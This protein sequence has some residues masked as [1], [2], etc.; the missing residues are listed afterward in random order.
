MDSVEGRYE[1]AA[2]L[3]G[4]ASFL[5][6]NCNVVAFNRDTEIN[7][8]REALGISAFDGAFEEGA[9]LSVRQVIALATSLPPD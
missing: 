5:K 1:R 3:W 4:A 8:L 6:M 7:R 9:R 2:K